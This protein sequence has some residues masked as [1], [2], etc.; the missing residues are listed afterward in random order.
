MNPSISVDDV[1][2]NACRSSGLP[3]SMALED[4]NNSLNEIYLED[5]YKGLC[6]TF[7]YILIWGLHTLP[8]VNVYRNR[9]HIK[10]YTKVTTF[11]KQSGTQRPPYF[12]TTMQLS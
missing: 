7:S 4:L 8:C 9:S 6:T 10:Q 12:L 2:H 5:T 1:K 3:V 11:Q